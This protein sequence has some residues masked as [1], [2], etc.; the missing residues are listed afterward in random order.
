MYNS[1]KSSQVF[2]QLNLQPDEPFILWAI[3]SQEVQPLGSLYVQSN[4]YK[5]CYLIVILQGTNQRTPEQLFPLTLIYS[6]HVVS[7]DLPNITEKPAK[8][9][10]QL[11]QDNRR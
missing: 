11:V 10:T 5:F 8:Q 1:E 7:I 3:A 9:Y 2:Q 4:T 6:E